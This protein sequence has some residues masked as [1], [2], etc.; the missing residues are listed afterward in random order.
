MKSLDRARVP[1]A[2]RMRGGNLTSSYF[3]HP[4]FSACLTPRH[5]NL[6]Q[7]G[8]VNGY[9]EADRETGCGGKRKTARLKCHRVRLTGFRGY[10]RSFSTSGYTSV[11]I[12]LKDV[13]RKGRQHMTQHDPEQSQ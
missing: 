12:E 3:D 1:I 8:V 2:S 6:R 7:V 11:G 9:R 10:S 4:S 5:T 13:R